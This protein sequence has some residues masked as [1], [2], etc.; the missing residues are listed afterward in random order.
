MIETTGK[1]L[2]PDAIGIITAFLAF[3]TLFSF[4]FVITDWYIFNCYATEQERKV[5]SQVIV[6]QDEDGVRYAM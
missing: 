6:C 5:L 2:K 1:A 3:F 4:S